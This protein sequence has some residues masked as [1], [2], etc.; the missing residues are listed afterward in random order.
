MLGS[1]REA[2]AAATRGVGEA[3]PEV[4][5]STRS[6]PRASIISRSRSR[7]SLTGA[8]G[9]A[10]PAL[11][12]SPRGSSSASG[13]SA[14]GARSG[15]DN[16]LHKHALVRAEIARRL[17]H[18]PEASRLYEQAIAAAREGG[19]VQHEA[20]ACELAAEFYRAR[21]LAHPPT[22][23][24]E[25][26]APA[27]SAGAPTPRWSS[28]IS[29]T[30]HLAPR[31]PIAPT[32]TFAVRAEQ[33][34]VLSVVKAAQSISGELKLPR[35]LETL[36]RIVVE[37][38]GAEEGCVLLVRDEQLWIAAI[39]TPGAR[40][41]CS[42]RARR[43]R[44]RC[45]S[46]SST[47][48]A[49]A[50]S[51]CC[52]TTPPPGTPSWRT[53]ISGASARDRCCAS[54]S[55]ARP[56]SSACSTWKT[57]SPPGRSPPG[58]SASSSCSPRSRRSR[59]RTRCSMPRWSRRTPSG[60]GRNRRSRPIRRCSRPS[61]TTR[62]RAVYV[63]DHEGRFLL[64]NRQVGALL[65]VPSEQLLGRTDADLFPAPFAEAVREHERKVLETGA[66]MEWE[67]D[68]AAGGRAAHVPVDQIPSRRGGHA[69]RALRH[70]H[71]HHRA[72]AGRAGRA[73]PGRG[74]PQADDAGLQRDLRERGAAPGARALGSVRRRGARPRTGHR[75]RRPSQGCPASS[76]K[77]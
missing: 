49:G 6:S 73:L 44:P 75:A 14:S 1:P 21:G 67:E 74:E 59:W 11:G 12:C 7:P 53:S 37:H 64:A 48:F 56:G 65:G 38:A 60:G 40:Y 36:L 13:S 5:G 29:A 45:R 70:L 26:P 24:C 69:R 76:W 61:S 52:S 55:C 47:M 25:T 4:P 77:R 16:F 54:R 31:K 35:L 46:P 33:F 51:A 8:R 22:A 27:I 28:S 30:P 19:F 17:G 23:T 3:P 66:P 50:T 72:Q 18:E 43:L 68:G 41:G 10:L 20:I 32:V 34:D 2:L 42:M 71:R 15:P 39:E 57:T 63:K 58:G 9:G 62:R